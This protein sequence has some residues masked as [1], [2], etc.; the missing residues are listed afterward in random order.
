MKKKLLLFTILLALL[1]CAD[2]SKIQGEWKVNYIENNSEITFEKKDSMTIRFDSDN[3]LII[4]NHGR[5]SS[6]SQYELLDH[7]SI[8]L[9]FSNKKHSLYGTYSFVDGF[10]KIK[11]RILNDTAYIELYK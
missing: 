2:K 9:N 3:S 7:D 1:S 4:S 8:I 11:G 10:L 5:V 6:N